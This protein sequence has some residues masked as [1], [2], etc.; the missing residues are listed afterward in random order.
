MPRLADSFSGRAATA[1]PWRVA[2]AAFLANPDIRFGLQALV[3]PL[4][5]PFDLMRSQHAHAVRAG[6]L[7]NS[8]LASR[9]FERALDSLEHFALGPFA[10][11]V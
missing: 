8:M 5:L 4:H 7:A 3:D 2:P 11:G 1:W 6:L 9:D 10:R